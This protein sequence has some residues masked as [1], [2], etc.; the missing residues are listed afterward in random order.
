MNNAVLPPKTSLLKVFFVSQGTSWVE[1]IRI[2]SYNVCYTKLLR[3][4]V[5]PDKAWLGPPLIHRPP[6]SR[7][8]RAACQLLRQPS[9]GADPAGTLV[10]CPLALDT[11]Q[12]KA[13][14]EGAQGLRQEC[15]LT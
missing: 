13:P 12:K 10:E 15:S 7:A 9:V 11:A 2:T 4:F 6:S 3:H 8:L 1:I 5:R 14:P